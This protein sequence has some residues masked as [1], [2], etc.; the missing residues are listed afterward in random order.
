M[1]KVKRPKI[2]PKTAVTHVIESQIM[3]VGTPARVVSTA[4]HIEVMMPEDWQGA[5]HSSALRNA[6]GRRYRITVDSRCAKGINVGQLIAHPTPRGA[7]FLRCQYSGWRCGNQPGLLSTE[8]LDTAEDLAKWRMRL[9]QYS[10]L[11][12]TMSRN[13]LPIAA[14]WTCDSSNVHFGKI[15]GTGI[16][17]F[18]LVDFPPD[19]VFWPLRQFVL[20]SADLRGNWVESVKNWYANFTWELSVQRYLKDSGMMGLLKDLIVTKGYDI[21]GAGLSPDSFGVLVDPTTPPSRSSSA[22]VVACVML[23][24][25]PLLKTLKDQPEAVREQYFVHLL[26]VM[27]M[28]IGTGVEMQSSG[29]GSIFR[30]ER[31]IWKALAVALPIVVSLPVA[32][33]ALKSYIPAMDGMVHS[34]YGALKDNVK[35]MVTMIAISNFVGFVNSGLHGIYE[36][37][38]PAPIARDIARAA[39]S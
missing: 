33:W 15:R 21:A 32:E 23:P 20:S 34:M 16:V 17:G 24:P 11:R 31:T 36:S 22:P 1:P 9:E 13:T 12:S 25:M 8:I 29:R 37:H 19:V 7:I 2:I 18:V 27:Y 38:T 14:A 5:V 39:R 6:F 35:M 3:P 10:A 28:E 26:N 4:E 30:P